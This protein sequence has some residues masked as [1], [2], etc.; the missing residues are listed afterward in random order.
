MVT[1]S[2][3]F[4]DATGAFAAPFPIPSDP[5]YLDINFLFQWGIADPL[6]GIFASFSASPLRPVCGSRSATDHFQP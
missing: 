5:G 3:G 4:T 6:G 2:S 1:D